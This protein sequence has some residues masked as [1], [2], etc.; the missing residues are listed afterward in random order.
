MT[1]G[2]PG[3]PP[4]PPFAASLDLGEKKESRNG[5]TTTNDRTT[6]VSAEV[7]PEDAL[8]KELCARAP[9]LSGRQDER[10]RKQDGRAARETCRMTF[11]C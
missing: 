11:T 2:E 1:K 9:V 6:A 7:E 5:R 10:E 4:S 8:Q 3:E